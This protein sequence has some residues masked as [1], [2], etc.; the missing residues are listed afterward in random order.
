MKNNIIW[1]IYK[2]EKSLKISLISGL[3]AVS[4]SFDS[5]LGINCIPKTLFPYYSLDLL[6]R[7]GRPREE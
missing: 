7:E 1:G 2:K 4:D 5:S 6:L 3:F